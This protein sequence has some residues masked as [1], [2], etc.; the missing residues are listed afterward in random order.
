MYSGPNP[1][2]VNPNYPDHTYDKVT[3]L[4]SGEQKKIIQDRYLAKYGFSREQYQQVFSGAPLKSLSASESYRTFSLLLRDARSANM[5]KLN[6][7]GPD[8]D[9]QKKRYE[10]HQSFLDSDDSKKYREYMRDKAK[11]QHEEQGLADAVRAY[12]NER[13]EGSQN[14]QK[15]RERFLRDNPVYRPGV[16]DKSKETYIRNHEAGLHNDPKGTKKKQYKD[17]SLTYQSS[18]ELDFL[19]YCESAGIL[20]LVQNA[21]TLR[22]KWYPRKYYLPDYVVAESMVVEVKSWYIEKLHNE[23]YGLEHL[24]EK[25]ALVERHGFQ[26]LYVL[27]KDYTELNAILSILE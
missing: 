3:C 11:K 2:D 10:G 25:R 23:K 14:Q 13:Y 16:V 1:K 12:F 8:S 19:E 4:V 17:T 6:T 24:N 20:H 5:T 26:W 27:D 7:S 18:Y 9:F 21:K 15:R 22:D